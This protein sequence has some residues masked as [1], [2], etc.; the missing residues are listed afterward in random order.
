MHVIAYLSDWS[1][2]IK[3]FCCCF[4]CAYAY[5]KKERAAVSISLSPPSCFTVLERFGAEYKAIIHSAH[6][7]V[8]MLVLWL[9]S[10]ALCLCLCLMY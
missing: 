3:F 1:W 2:H 4:S 8:L 9:S 7:Y 6:A 10:L 5:V